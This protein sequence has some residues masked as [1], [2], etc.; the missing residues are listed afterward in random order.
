MSS[1]LTSAFNSE[2]SSA[3]NG[4]LSPRLNSALSTEMNAGV[5]VPVP[6]PAAGFV[7]KLCQYRVMCIGERHSLGKAGAALPHSKAGRPCGKAV[8][9][10]PQSKD[11]AVIYMLW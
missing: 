10:L 4:A 2:L 9:P 5:P 11:L 8:A 3:L 1:G 6:G 7:R